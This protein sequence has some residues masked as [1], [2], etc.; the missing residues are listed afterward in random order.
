EA[1]RVGNVRLIVVDPIVTAV[2]GDSHKNGDVRRDLQPLVDLASNLDAALVGITHL[3]KSA[4]GGDPVTRVLGSVAFVAVARVVL[5]AA[6]VK[7]E[8]GEDRRILVRGKS[9]IGPDEGG[10]A[11]A[12][13]Q[14]EPIPGIAAS[15]IQWSEAVEGTARELLADQQSGDADSEDGRSALESAMDFLREALADGMTP[16]KTIQAEARENGVSPRTLRRA[17]EALGVVKHKGGSGTDT[18]WYWSLPHRSRHQDDQ[19]GQHVQA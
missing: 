19:G 3:S 9:N 16:A 2:T 18:R 1:E 13:A 14:A 4:V 8:E 12:I 11:Y 6:K 10:F 17:A 5:V 7:T 15:Y